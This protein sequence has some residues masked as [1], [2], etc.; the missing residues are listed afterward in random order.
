MFL[1]FFL[2]RLAILVA[3][4]LAMAVGELRPEALYFPDRPLISMWARW[5]SG[6][7]LN[8]A[9]QGYNYLIDR[10]S[11]VAFFPLYPSLMRLFSLGSQDWEVL[12]VTGWIISNA[13]ALI[14]FYLLYRLILL[15]YGPRVGRYAVWLLAFFPTSLFLSVVYAEGLFL[16]LTVAAFY[17]ARKQRWLAAGLLG[18]LS[19]VTR[20]VG[21]LIILPLAWEWYQQRPRRWRNAAPLALIPLGL[22]AYML[23][24]ARNF[25]DPLAFSA[26]QAFWDRAVSPLTIL[27]RL[28]T[29]VRSPAAF[30]QEPG[31]TTYEIT[32]VFLALFLLMV[33]FWKQRL[34]Y[35]LFATYSIAIPLSTIQTVSFSRFMLVIFPLFIAMAQIL[36]RPVLFRINIIG[37]FILQIVLVS[38]WALS[39]WVA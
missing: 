29:L 24:L 3:G 37:M 32:F 18:A 16:A 21:V 20:S 25:G 5:D 34:S 4:Q 35:A 2:S 22:G 13:A 23:Y 26:T 6:W 8:I 9:T 33:V 31:I 19:G 30:L 7:Y 12:I 11:N 15:D 10:Q 27:D 38:R 39:Y 1:P 36:Y 17:A 28:N 14:A